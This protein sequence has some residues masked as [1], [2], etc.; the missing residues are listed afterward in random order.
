MNKWQPKE[1]FEKQGTRCIAW[2]S[3]DKGFEDITTEVYY[4]RGCWYWAD[5]ECPVRK[6]DLIK[7]MMLYPEPGDQVDE[8]E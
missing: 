5:G 6:P 8:K 4:F 7:G 2:M 1:K 3:S